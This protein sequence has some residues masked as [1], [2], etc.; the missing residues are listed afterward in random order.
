LDSAYKLV[1]YDG[2]PILKLSAQKVTEPG[3]K[4]VFR[5]PDGDVVGL[6]DEA[7]PEEHGPLLVPV[8]R[9]GQRTGPHRTLETARSLFRSDLGHVPEAARRIE[10]PVAPAPTTS[11]ALDELYARARADALERAGLA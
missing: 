11:K 7:V 6:R 4:Q 5:G 3:R 8:M 10:D 2:R 1:E 9:G